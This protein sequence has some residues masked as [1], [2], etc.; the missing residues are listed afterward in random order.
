MV[1]HTGW[2]KVTAAPERAAEEI[3]YSVFCSDRE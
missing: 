3:T 1:N 2:L